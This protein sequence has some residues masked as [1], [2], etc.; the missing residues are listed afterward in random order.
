MGRFLD[1]FLVLIAKAT[2]FLRATTKKTQQLYFVS[3]FYSVFL[4]SL[5]L[6]CFWTLLIGVFCQ[7]SC[8]DEH[9]F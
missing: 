7:R 9:L 6:N 1:G 2:I 4:H 5:R 8:S 3:L